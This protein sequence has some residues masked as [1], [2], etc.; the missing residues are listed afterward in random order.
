MTLADYFSRNTLSRDLF[1]LVRGEKLGEGTGR[2]VYVFAPDPTL[3]IKFE[4][5]GRSFQNILEWDTWNCYALCNAVA[6][7]LAPC[8]RI[9]ENGSILLQKRTRPIRKEELPAKVPTWAMD[10]KQGNWGL[11]EGRPVMHDYGLIRSQLPNRLVKAD[12][13]GV[14]DFHE[15]E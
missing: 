1:D 6:K 12:W 11:Y 4:T 14:E 7:W 9:S 15:Q 13:W 8:V 10:L 2:V 5:G 3:V